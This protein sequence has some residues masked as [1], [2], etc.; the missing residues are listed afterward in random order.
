MTRQPKLPTPYAPTPEITTAIQTHLT[1][2]KLTCQD[3][4]AIAAQAQVAPGEI[5]Q[6][7]DTLGTR[8][9]RCQLGLFGYPGKQG[10]HDSGVADLPVPE[11]LQ[12]A[13]A[14]M[15]DEDR[16]LMCAQAWILADRFGISRMQFGWIAE[17]L[18]V[19]FV[20]CQLGAF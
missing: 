13:I 7:A 19:K 4:F 10:W 2:G 14:E 6:A 18:K 8:L 16:H 9:S 5:G 11:G 20:T 3:A 15:V 17:N 12:S 1:D